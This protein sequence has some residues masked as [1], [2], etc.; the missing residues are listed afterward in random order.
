[1]SVLRVVAE[2]A[3]V[4]DSR[5]QRRAGLTKEREAGLRRHSCPWGCGRMIFM[6]HATKDVRHEAP[7]C[8]KFGEAV[9]KAEIARASRVEPEPID[10]ASFPKVILGPDGSPPKGIDFVETT[11]RARPLQYV[12]CPE[13][14]LTCPPECPRKQKED[15]L[16]DE[17]AKITRECAS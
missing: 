9:I 3:R 17:L 12:G 14:G 8:E 10:G 1:V 2:G 15:A 5:R 11:I 16:Y 7:A 6:N 13:H 4:S